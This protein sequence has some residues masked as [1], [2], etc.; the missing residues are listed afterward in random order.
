VSHHVEHS[1]QNNALVECVV[2]DNLEF[3]ARQHDR[4][5]EE[6]FKIREVW[7]KNDADN[8]AADLQENEIIQAQIHRTL[9]KSQNIETQRKFEVDNF[10][11]Q[12]DT[13]QAHQ[14]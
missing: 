5:T 7:K 4:E 6:A 9:V 11:A 14:E 1:Q 12:R 8:R 3:W 2:D 10:K 13:D